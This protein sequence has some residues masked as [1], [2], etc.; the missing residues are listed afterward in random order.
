MSETTLSEKSTHE[1]DYFASIR[2]AAKGM[3]LGV[4]NYDEFFAG[5]IRSIHRGLTFA[6]EEG[7]K[8][9]GILPDE[10]SANE[11][12]Q[13]EA[14]IFEQINYIHGFAEFIEQ[15]TKELGGKWTPIYNRIQMWGNKYAAVRTLAASLACKNKKKVWRLNL[16]RV[17]K[18]HCRSCAGFAGRV[19]RY[20]VWQRNGALPQ[21]FRL[22]CSGLHCGCGFEDTEERITPGPF[23]RRLLKQ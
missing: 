5:M 12:A 19:Y 11:L 13:R 23:P 17:T 16:V 2:A 9:C 7:T 15:N 4:Y 21:G 1:S 18:E 8:E 6:F 20:G 10:L 14:A 3:W 22:E